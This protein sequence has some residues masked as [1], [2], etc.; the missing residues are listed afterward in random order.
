MKNSA[1]WGALVLFGFA[2]HLQSV[3]AAEVVVSG[4]PAKESVFAGAYKS[5]RLGRLD[6]DLR[7]FHDP[8]WR[9]RMTDLF[10]S[11]GFRVFRLH[12]NPYQH[13]KSPVIEWGHL[14]PLWGGTVKD[15]LGDEE[16]LAWLAE[17]D[18]KGIVQVNADNFYDPRRK[19]IFELRKHPEY[20][21][22]A[23]AEQAE[24]VALAKRRGYADRIYY[25]ELGN[26]DWQTTPPEFFA[27]VCARFMR[28]MKKADPAIRLGVVAQAPDWDYRP[29]KLEGIVGPFMGLTDPETNSR[30]PNK[31]WSVGDTAQQPGWTTRFLTELKRLGIPAEWVDFAVHHAYADGPPDLA[32]GTRKSPTDIPPI[33]ADWAR[34]Q[35]PFGNACG[36]LGALAALLDRL[37][38]ARTRVDVNEFRRGGYNSFYNRSFMNA[39]ANADA[40]MSLVQHPRVSGALIWDSFND[41]DF[42]EDG[43]RVWSR[44]QGWGIFIR[45]GDRFLASPVAEMYQLFDRLLADGDDVLTCRADSSVY[46]LATRGSRG[47][48]VL[49][50]NKGDEC[51]VGIRFDGVALSPQGRA[52]VCELQCDDLGAFTVHPSTGEVRSFAVVD[53][54][55]A[56]MGGNHLTYRLRRHSLTLFEISP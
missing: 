46:A 11:Y 5:L 54:P 36:S 48:K 56:V 43:K 44:D 32:T 3:A 31:E 55:P 9:Q 21:D 38:Y 34:Y 37:G 24:L 29:P 41:G 23:A 35:R 53:R 42:G 47:I 25:W 39:L 7:W 4:S 51:D 27:N 1:L 30:P 22:A 6:V 15:V 50:L 13:W 8:V 52:T 12:F 40:W 16:F 14:A 20:V 18:F 49:V 45:V 26:E 17:N 19:G 10:K 2:S 28:A 33:E